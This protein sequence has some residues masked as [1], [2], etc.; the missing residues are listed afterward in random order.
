MATGNKISPKKSLG[1][2]WLTDKKSLENIINLA[3][4]NKTDTVLEIGPG[5][6]ELTKLLSAQAKQII[7]VEL[8][9]KLVE[10]L[11][12]LKLPNLIIE[13]INILNFNFEKAKD[14]KLVANIP[15]Y[16]TGKI[17]RLISET[18]NRPKLAVLLVQK[19]IADKLTATAGNLSIL[20]L[21]CQ[22]FWQV[23]K[24]PII[25]ADKFDPP[26]KVNSQ[27]VK[28]TPII[29]TL[30]NEKQKALFRL[31]R[32]GFSSKRKTLLNN[33]SSGYRVDKQ[34]IESVLSLA[35]IDK[36]RRAQTLSANEWISVLEK[37]PYA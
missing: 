36:N 32:I 13:N 29:P 20:G 28:L 12:K 22:Y 8:D 14:Y 11:I 35:S 30:S 23:K 19:E 21:T 37:L 16:L 24:G 9:S 26:P 5:T 27:I 18:S 4:I 1:Q 3:G 25:T 2:H 33:L 31:I 7:A 15:Y 34:T 17:I 10:H 6:G